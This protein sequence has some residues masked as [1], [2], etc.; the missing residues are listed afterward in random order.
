MTRAILFAFL[1][2]AGCAEVREVM[3]LG[4]PAGHTE[5]ERK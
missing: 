4:Q 2:L 1:L 5:G 3:H